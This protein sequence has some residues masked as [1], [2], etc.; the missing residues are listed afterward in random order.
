[1][2]HLP[3]VRFVMPFLHFLFKVLKRLAPIAREW[4]EALHQTMQEDLARPAVQ[5]RNLFHFSVVTTV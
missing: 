1:M 3:K 2:C 4:S 5:A